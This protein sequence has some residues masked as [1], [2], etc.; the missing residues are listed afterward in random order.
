[1]VIKKK[2]GR[3]D[4][5][6][7]IWDQE[8]LKKARVLV[9]GAGTLGNEICKNLALIGVGHITVVD[10]DVIEEVNLNRC[11]FFRKEDIGRRKSE[12]LVERLR[13]LNP[14][15][16]VAY[17]DC[18]VNIDIG[19]GLFLEF[20]IVIGGLDNIMAR[21]KVNKYAY[22]TGTPYVDGAIEGLNGQMQIVMPPDTACYACAVPPEMQAMRN[23]HVSCSGTKLDSRGVSVPMVSTTASIIGALQVQEAMNI[24][25][26]GDSQLKGKQLRFDQAHSYR[27][28]MPQKTE[29]NTHYDLYENTVEK[30]KWC[31]GHHCF[32]DS[33][34]RISLSEES[35]LEELVAALKKELN[36]DPEIQNDEL[37]CYRLH[38]TT[39]GWEKPV[40]KLKKAV[41]IDI[42]RMKCPHCGEMTILDDS[43]DVLRSEFSHMKIVEFGIPRK[44]ILMVN[45]EIP[46]FLQGEGEYSR[47]GSQQA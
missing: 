14:E 15:I 21:E 7:T 22:C 44:Q 40:F 33:I 36:I 37:I 12:V 42:N 13:E 5:Q 6:K 28:S 4:R 45:R 35:T 11:L 29:S 1:M 32:K 25:H 39:C 8:V 47:E 20:D 10:F 46:I 30:K 19:A 38:C 26:T 2:K 31:T 18:D 41:G 43:D 27:K 3:Y 23:V 16:E 17:I 24:I 34:K 9:V